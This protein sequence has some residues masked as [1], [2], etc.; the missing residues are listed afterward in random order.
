MSKS[1]W[2]QQPRCHPVKCG[3]SGSRGLQTQ[4]ALHPM[5]ATVLPCL[6]ARGRAR[7]CPLA[8]CFRLSGLVKTNSHPLNLPSS[9]T[10]FFPFFGFLFQSISV[11]W[12]VC[13][14]PSSVLA[15]GHPGRSGFM[16]LKRCWCPGTPKLAH[17]PRQP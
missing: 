14:V 10:F 5:G 4:R 11:E 7:L 2:T 17:V 15:L 13:H 9:L 8:A 1:Q 12:S 6:N 16:V 3:D